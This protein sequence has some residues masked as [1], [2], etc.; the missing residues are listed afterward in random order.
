MKLE[1]ILKEK[2]LKLLDKVKKEVP[3]T[4][5]GRELMNNLLERLRRRGNL[6]VEM[7]GH[8]VRRVRLNLSSNYFEPGEKNLNLWVK[9]FVANEKYL[10]FNYR[11]ANFRASDVF[12][13]GINRVCL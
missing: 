10:M 12:G 5:I 3:K 11:G 7:E 1:A 9:P 2:D 13:D 4:S 8:Y 6:M